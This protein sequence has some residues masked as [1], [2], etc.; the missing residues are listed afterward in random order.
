MPQRAQPHLVQRTIDLNS[1]TGEA[2]GEAAAREDRLMEYAS[3]VNIAC[4]FHAGGHEEMARCIVRAKA[5]G[6]AIGAHPSYPDRANFGRA[7]MDL[8]ASEIENLTAHQ[9]GS[10]C[11]QAALHGAAVR[12]VKLHGALA[13]LA[14][15]DAGTAKAAV[16]AIKAVDANLMVLAIA[17]SAM[18]DAG[19]AAGLAVAEEIFAD[20]AYDDD[21]LLIP[22]AQAQAVITS[23]QEGAAR[24]R[25][26]LEEGALIT[27][28]GKKIPAR[29]D[30]VS[31]HGDTENALELAQMCARAIGDAG[32]VIRSF[33]RP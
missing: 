9:I 12:H 27:L 11:G 29:M 24:L 3:S 31:I 16:R 28:S 32:F 5:K 13:N 23:A 1:D 15:Y 20:R 6:L 2:H 4:G 14:A 22:R 21:G 17:G 8:H 19:R 26:M 25:T 33:A 18:A 10:L 30:S 7:A